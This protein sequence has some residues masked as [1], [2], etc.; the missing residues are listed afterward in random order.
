MSDKGFDIIFIAQTKLERFCFRFETPIFKKNVCV[1]I[2]QNPLLLY[3]EL[4][5]IVAV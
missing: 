4:T 5:T 2:C 1:V 3:A